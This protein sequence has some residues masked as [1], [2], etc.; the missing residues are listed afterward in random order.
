MKT[1]IQLAVLGLLVGTASAAEAHHRHVDYDAYA[2][3]AYG[4]QLPFPVLRAPQSD[5]DNHATATGGPSGGLPG[6]S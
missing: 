4:S 6:G 3:F 1:L 2:P 5:S